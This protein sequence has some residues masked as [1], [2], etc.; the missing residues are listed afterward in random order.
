MYFPI[1][2]TA[3]CTGHG[4]FHDWIHNNCEIHRLLCMSQLV[5]F[6]NAPAA[7]YFSIERIPKY[8]GRGVFRVWSLRI[9]S[10]IHRAR[11]TS[12]VDTLHNMPAVVCF[13]IGDTP[14]CT[15]SSRFRDWKHSEIDGRGVFRRMSDGELTKRKKNTGRGVFRNRTHSEIQWPGRISR[16]VAVFEYCFPHL[17]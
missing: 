10:E 16:H 12:R 9:R 7:V 17:T 15:G 3:R 1:E 11:F 8:T 4:V 6:R 13:A 5:Q 2:N 14:K